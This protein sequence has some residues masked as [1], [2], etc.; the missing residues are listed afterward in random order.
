[1]WGTRTNKNPLRNA[2]YGSS[3]MQYPCEKAT[4][5]R[6]KNRGNT[7]TKKAP[8]QTKT[9]HISLGIQKR[10]LNGSTFRRRFLAPP[11]AALN[12][13]DHFHP[14]TKRYGLHP[15]VHKTTFVVLHW[16]VSK[17]LKYVWIESRSTVQSQLSHL[18]IQHIARIPNTVSIGILGVGRNCV[19]PIAKP[20]SRGV[21]LAAYEPFLT[22]TFEANPT[23]PICSHETTSIRLNI[24]SKNLGLFGGHA[25][26]K[27]RMF[28]LWVGQTISHGNNPNNCHVRDFGASSC[29]SRS[30]IESK[31]LVCPQLF[32]FFAWKMNC[33]QFTASLR[34]VV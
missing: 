8:K 24:R 33:R 4:H 16:N 20:A 34:P 18:N 23:L 9:T 27:F 13:A 7:Q 28:L 12:W 32:R 31:R 29:I 15:S 22:L 11:P 26:E 19:L 1:M 10:D 17:C 25:S 21:P 6:I 3:K 30:T 5:I 14:G 2:S